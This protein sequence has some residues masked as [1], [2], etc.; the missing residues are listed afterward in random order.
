MDGPLVHTVRERTFLR[1]RR[2]SLFFFLFMESRTTATSFRIT[3]TSIN[4]LK[5]KR[6]LN[7]SFLK[8]KHVIEERPVNMNSGFYLQKWDY[9]HRYYENWI[10]QWVPIFGAFLQSSSELHS[11]QKCLQI[12][13][14]R[15][16]VVIFIL[17]TALAQGLVLSAMTFVKKKTWTG[18]KGF[19]L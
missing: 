19:I 2:A 11:V 18:W 14:M 12:F 7:S 1:L 4:H 10:V 6:E 9:H 13:T 16:I 8:K 15:K 5:E 3:Y 17:S